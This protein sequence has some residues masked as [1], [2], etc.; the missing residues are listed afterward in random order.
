MMP[1]KELEKANKIYAN[2]QKDKLTYRQYIKLQ[3]EIESLYK[4]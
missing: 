4:D 3:N 1:L 2:L